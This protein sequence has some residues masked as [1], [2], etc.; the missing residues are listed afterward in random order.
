M[1]LSST[2]KSFPVM[3]SKTATLM[4]VVSNFFIFS[5]HSLLH[6]VARFSGD[7]GDD[8]GAATVFS[9][10]LRHI[11]EMPARTANDSQLSNGETIIENNVHQCLKRFL[12][13]QQNPDFGDLHSD[14]SALLNSL[15]AWQ[16]PRADL[17]RYRWE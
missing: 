16:S 2:T 1:S 5:E 15:H 13:D 12:I 14:S 6:H 7:R 17:Y 11:D 4:P 3:H 9:P 10:S 8:F